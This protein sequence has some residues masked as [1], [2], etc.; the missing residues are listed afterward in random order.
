MVYVHTVDEAEAERI[1][2]F[3]RGAAICTVAAVLLVVAAVISADRWLPAV[4][5]HDSERRFVEPYVSFADQAVPASG[6]EEVARYVEALGSRVAG[7]MDLPD[8]LRLTIRFVDMAEVN[9]FA[10]LGGYVFVTE[11]LVKAVDNENSLAMV[12]AHEIAHV[13]NRDPLLSAGR[14][15]MAGLLL[16]AISGHSSSP[17]GIGDLGTE[18]A[19]NV[20]SR[21]QESRADAQAL[22]AVQQVFGHV[23]GATRLF[24]IV[25]E[26]EDLAGQRMELLSTH[27]DLQARIAGLNAMAAAQGWEQRS[28][29]PYPA[30]IA[31]RLKTL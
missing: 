9:A 26:T 2:R 10:T 28:V 25:K 3:L 24:E 14:G 4:V 21:D 29:Q 6:E 15:M 1:A 18:V 17:F 8:D 30:A 12:I 19:L 20:Y 11:G 23:G 16:T 27:P 7:F 5:S 13:R 31:E 22:V